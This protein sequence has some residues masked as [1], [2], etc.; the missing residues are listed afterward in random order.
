[1][2]RNFR[3]FLIDSEKVAFDAKHRKT[4]KF[5]MQKYYNA[6][7]KGKKRFKSLEYIK[8]YC[9]QRKRVALKKLDKYLLEFEANISKNNATVLWA[10]NTSDVK[11]HLLKIIKENSASLI[12][13][14][15][16]MTTE[17]VDF[18]KIA[19]DQNLTSIETDLGEYIVQVAGEKPYHIVTPAMHKSKKD[20]N[21]LFDKEF[22]IGEGHTAEYLT[23]FVRFKLRELFQDADIGVTG[24]NFLIADIGGVAVTENEGNA[25]F[26]TAFPK[27]HIVIS[28][29]EKIIPSLNDLDKFWPLLSTHGTGQAITAYNS[30]FTGP[31]KNEDELG[32]EKMYVIL[33]NNERT[34]L[35]K[36]NSLSNSL[37]CIRCGACLNACPVYHNIG[38]YTYNNCYSGPI[39]SIISPYFKSFKDYSHLSY[40][41]TL[42]GK[43]TENC[44]VKIDLHKYLLA[45]RVLKN[46]SGEGL[47][48]FRISIKIFKKL[49][50]NSFLFNLSFPFLYNVLKDL[51]FKKVF[52]KR[53]K[54]PPI[55]KNFTKTFK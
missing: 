31:K 13:K 55:K 39:G 29:I 2:N 35:L 53:R 51:F 23:N 42:C 22:A 21:D 5:T 17:E 9:A 24:A 30:I 36:E 8:E 45:N 48:S 19:N 14:S 27:M 46:R 38:G 50:Q 43:C 37:S 26:S 52:G 20:I 6:V 15:K 10:E 25:I 40:A 1:M 28:G 12:V 16:S 7:V 49:S 18:N 34:K 4:I 33:L 11:T 32:P 47:N 41:C 44:P 54:L 3:K